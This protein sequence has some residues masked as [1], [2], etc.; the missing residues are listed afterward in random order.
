[1]VILILGIRY[2]FLSNLS[3]KLVASL[4]KQS[5]VVTFTYV[6]HV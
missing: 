5:K 6:D 4:P 1:M 3:E 2:K